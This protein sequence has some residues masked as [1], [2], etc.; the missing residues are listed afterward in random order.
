MTDTNEFQVFG[1]P[2]SGTNLIEYIL[3]HYF[4]LNYKNIYCEKNNTS[5]KLYNC[6]K[7]YAIKHQIPFINNNKII[8]IY[9]ELYLKNISSNNYFDN[10]S[11]KQQ[12]YHEYLNYIERFKNNASVLIIKYEE[13]IKLTKENIIKMELFIGKKSKQYKLPKYKLNKDGG[14]TCSKE[15]FDLNK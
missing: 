13:L 11:T 5:M 3:I 9:K 14:Q 1:L 6:D 8:I 10:Y 2:R 4:D 7:K 15:L 12:T